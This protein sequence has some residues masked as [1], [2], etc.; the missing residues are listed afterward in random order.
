MR[1]GVLAWL[2]RNVS[3][4]QLAV[5]SAIVGRA[6]SARLPAASVLDELSILG[7]SWYDV[8]LFELR[9]YSEWCRSSGLPLTTLDGEQLFA[10]ILGPCRKNG[11]HVNVPRDLDRFLE[12]SR[13]FVQR[14]LRLDAGFA[15]D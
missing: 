10:V 14:L 15:R 4:A 7:F 1:P 3:D 5:W 2:G 6:H 11:S 8:D 13:T 9:T 12:S